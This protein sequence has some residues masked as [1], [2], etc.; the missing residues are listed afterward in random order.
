MTALAVLASAAAQ[1]FDR[2]FVL[3]HVAV[4]I[5]IPSLSS[6][7]FFPAFW[8]CCITVTAPVI[9]AAAMLSTVA[10]VLPCSFCPVRYS[11]CT[12][13]CSKTLFKPGFTFGSHM[14]L[15]KISTRERERERLSQSYAV[16]SGEE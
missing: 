6:E 14:N 9:S 12:Q 8:C 3:Q 15:H 1:M 13:L 4:F 5:H 10:A 11:C 16:I 7:L 2:S